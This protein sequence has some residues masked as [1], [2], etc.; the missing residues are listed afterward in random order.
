MAH[1]A[2]WLVAVGLA[3]TGGLY[4]RGWLRMRRARLALASPLRL[5]ALL[6]ATLLTAFVFLSPLNQWNERYLLAR[7]LQK[8]LLCLLAAPLFWLAHPWEII[9]W[10]LPSAA[11]RRLTGAVARPSPGK[12]LAVLATQPWMA[13]LFFNAAF[14]IW[15]DRQV[16]NW[17]LANPAWHTLGLMALGAAAVL[18]WWHVVG[19]G[20]QLHVA[21]IPWVCALYLVMIEISNMVIGVSMAFST[22]PIYAHYAATHLAAPNLR[23]DLVA[24]QAASGALLWV[25][26]SLVYIGA[27]LA[28][29]NRVFQK[30]GSDKAHYHPDWDSDERMIMPGLEHRLK[31]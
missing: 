31:E 23:F 12:A 1:F 25:T 11:R 15:H 16:A 9:V 13:W 8:V 29:L 14:L 28:V 5:T 7:T 22:Q 3:A 21:F 18:F 26:G 19:A 17:L 4:G 6:A 27:I 30:A 2:G 20:P 24:D 10:G